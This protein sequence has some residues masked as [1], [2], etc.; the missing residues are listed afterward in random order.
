VKLPSLSA[1][2]ACIGHRDL[3]RSLEAMLAGLRSDP[4]DDFLEDL[5]ETKAEV[6]R[7]LIE[8]ELGEVRRRLSP[9]PE[10]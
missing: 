10:K 7:L 4:P 9:P 5:E 6:E 2:P 8:L 3:H 1:V